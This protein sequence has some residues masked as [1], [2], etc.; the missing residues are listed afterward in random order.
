MLG[1]SRTSKLAA[2]FCILFVFGGSGAR[3]GQ[4]KSAQVA[5]QTTANPE[6]SSAAP[7]FYRDVLPILKNHCQR[8]HNVSGIA[9][10]PFETYDQVRGY[11]NVIRNV[12]QDKAM[13]PPFAIPEAGRVR[14]DL[15][16][17]SNEISTIAAWANAKA[18]AGEPADANTWAPAETAFKADLVLKLP[19]PISIQSTG[20]DCIYEIV[21]THFTKSRWVKLVEFVSDQPKN[22][23]QAVIFIR[24]RGSSWLRQAPVGT[25]FAATTLSHAEE[26]DP[27]DANILVVYAAGSPPAKWPDSM[28]KLIPAGADLV[29]RLQYVPN[30]KTGTDQS[31]VGLIFS[32][33][34]PS[35]RVITLQLAKTHASIPSGESDY[36]V[37]ARATLASEALLVSFFP[38]MYRLGTRFQY[39][40]IQANSNKNAPSSE[41]EVLLRVDFDLRWQSSY[42]LIE[43]RILKAG[44]TLHAV[45]WYDTSTSNPRNSDARGLVSLGDKYGDE[46]STGFF[47]IALPVRLSKNRLLIH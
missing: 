26:S 17:S 8:C 43:P 21:P 22:V 14:E 20:S 37:E 25:P 47:D 30:N 44:T 11:S 18:P 5:D 35:R 3:A 40:I 2:F 15:S 24:P 29:F 4:F 32:K 28:A 38:D 42:T 45:A 7:T 41:D 12:T 13:P 36:R 39:D 16:L 1:V 19:K 33:Q 34:R 31:G 6:R 10:M 9:P 46:P 27:A 23:R